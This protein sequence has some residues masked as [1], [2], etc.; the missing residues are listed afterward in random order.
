MTMLFVTCW[1]PGSGKSTWAKQFAKDRWYI[2]LNTD[3]LTATFYQ[4]NY[5]QWFATW[6]FFDIVR[7][8]IEKHWDAVVDACFVNWKT[9]SQFISL[10]PE[11]AIEWHIFDTSV[12][13]C[14]RRQS[15]R[16][17]VVDTA[18]IEWMARDIS[19]PTNQPL[20]VKH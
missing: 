10:F 16:D 9:R 18:I 20:Y 3:D 13:E 19:F 11:T 1:L 7:S 8:A 6:W 17:R 5:K 4:T 14:I 12:E 2:Y 15:L